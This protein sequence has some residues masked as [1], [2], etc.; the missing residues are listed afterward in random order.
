MLVAICIASYKRPEGLQRLLKGINHLNVSTSTINIEVVVVDNDANA[1]AKEV[2]EK[3]TPNFKWSLRYYIEPQRGISYVRNKAIANVSDDAEFVAFIDD[4]EVPEPSWLS[5]LL[6]VQRIYNA[7]VVTGPV[8][9]HFTK[10]AP[11]WVVRGKFFESGRYPTG[12]LLKVAFTNNVIVRSEIFKKFEQVFDHRFA[13]T[14]GEDCHFFMRLYHMGYKM[15]WADNAIVYEWISDSRTNMK[16]ILLRGY[17]TWGTH[18]LCEREFE[19]L[20][21]VQAIR[22]AK[23][24][25]LILIGVLLLVPS[26]T[27]QK[28]IFVKALLRIYRGCGTFSGLLGS[29]YQEYKHLE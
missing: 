2:C 24:S 23:G 25:A 13:I 15:V 6:S 4:D 26:F 3:I 1:S 27:F 18:S 9:P 19:P 11:A 21:K 10:E 22:V 17:R 20:I 5:E 14:G 7:D 12:C 29:P 28:H 16:W 8:L